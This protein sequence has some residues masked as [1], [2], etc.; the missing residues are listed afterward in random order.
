MARNEEKA[1]TLFNKWQ[2]FK[3]EFHAS[4]ANRRPLVAGECESLPDAEKWRRDIVSNITKNITAIRNA[5]LGEHRIRELNDEL[6]KLMKQKYYWEIRIRELGGNVPIGKQIYDIEG[7]E[8]PGAPGYRYFGA[9][10]DLPGVRELFAEQEHEET[11]R[12]QKASQKRS[13]KD[14][15]ENITPL[16]YGDVSEE[17]ERHLMELE[18]EYEQE[19]A[20]QRTTN[21]S[22]Q[23][24]IKEQEEI[25]E[26]EQL[27]LI[28]HRYI[29]HQL[30]QSES[31]EGTV[32]NVHADVAST[33]SS[34]VNKEPPINQDSTKVTSVE[35][36]HNHDSPPII[37]DNV[38]SSKQSLLDKLDSFF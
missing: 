35:N 27:L 34:I 31:S 8:L 12:Q 10:K 36:I 19:L 37:A 28:S 32:M 11:L 26:L 24:I 4:R 33:N 7:K 13:R 23:D 17:E 2:T 15:V 25:A 3:S 9:A 38:L 20:S 6:N 1:L 14:L 18:T 22:Y 16:Y 30:H 29:N 21:K 5:S